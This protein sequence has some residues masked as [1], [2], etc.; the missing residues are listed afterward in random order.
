MTT[1]MS[2]T[3]VSI[4]LRV[5]SWKKLIFY[6]FGINYLKKKTFLFRESAVY[7]FVQFKGHKKGFF[8]SMEEYVEVLNYVDSNG[9]SRI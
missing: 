1:K 8:L 6:G 4:V 9:L 5:D 7:P 3:L 2:L